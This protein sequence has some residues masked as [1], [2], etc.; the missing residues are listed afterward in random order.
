MTGFSTQAGSKAAVRCGR[1]LRLLNSQ[2]RTL[3]L[4]TSALHPK[5]IFNHL[6]EGR[7]L[8]SWLSAACA[9]RSLWSR[10]FL[11]PRWSRW[12]NSRQARGGVAALAQREPVTLN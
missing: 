6:P 11:T 1:D 2:E 4:W 3:T 10:G 5:P 9:S 12:R 8:Q 7:A